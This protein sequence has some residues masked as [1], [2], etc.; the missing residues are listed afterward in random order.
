MHA[1]YRSRIAGFTIVELLIVIVVIGIVATISVVTFSGIQKRAS[2]AAARAEY[3]SV[4][5]KLF[6]FNIDNNDAYPSSITSCPTP[7]S[8][9]T[10]IAP[11][12]S[13]TTYVYRTQTGT[14]PG[15][16]LT[17]TTPQMSYYRGK[18]EVTSVNEFMKYSDLAPYLDANG[19]RKY[20]IEFDIKSANPTVRNTMTVYFQNGSGTRYSGLNATIP[21]TTAYTHQSLTFTPVLSNAALTQAFLAF[22]GGPYGNGNI[23]TVK[24]VEVYLAD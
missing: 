3:S 22:Y 6:I 5:D 8:G 16:D 10:C 11:S 2:L 15:Y 9:A 12:S 17:I 20:R 1:Q 7:T 24:D 19:L 13:T 4:D 21:V 23:P 18:V 14:T